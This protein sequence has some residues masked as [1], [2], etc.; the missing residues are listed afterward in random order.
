MIEE[1]IPVFV[2]FVLSI[3]ETHLLL[4]ALEKPFRPLWSTRTAPLLKVPWRESSELPYY[5]VVCLQPSWDKPHRQLWEGKGFDYLPGAGDDEENWARGMTPGE[6]WADWRE[7][8]ESGKVP[9]KAAEGYEEVLRD[10]GSG[11]WIGPLDKYEDF[12]ATISTHLDVPEATKNMLHL[13]IPSGSPRT[14][15]AR[16]LEPVWSFYTSYPSASKLLISGPHAE[17]IALFLLVKLANVE[18]KEGVGKV[19]AGMEARGV[20]VPRVGMRAVRGFV[21][22]R[23]GQTQAT[24]HG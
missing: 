2:D 13:P 19:L 23:D 4:R 21:F 7:I 6:F 22:G 1:K 11:V 8:I 24:D 15:L 18:T 14:N 20:R 16:I 10:L 12:D 5:P 17:S 3:P 9:K